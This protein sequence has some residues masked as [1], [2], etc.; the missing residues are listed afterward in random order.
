[1]CNRPKPTTH[2]SGDMGYRFSDVPVL[3]GSEYAVADGR[4]WIS[5]TCE[6]DERGWDVDWDFE[7]FDELDVYL[8]DGEPV[9][10][11]PDAVY[12][13]VKAYL[14]LQPSIITDAAYDHALQSF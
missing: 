12:E 11:A 1:M 7:G 8:S 2:I 14:E 9:D 13:Q 6:R 3:L 10:P 5:Y 4:I